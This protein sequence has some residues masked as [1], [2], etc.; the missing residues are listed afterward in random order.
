MTSPN[1]GALYIAF[2]SLWFVYLKLNYLFQ[3]L[4]AEETYQYENLSKA[5][6]A[7]FYRSVPNARKTRDLVPSNNSNIEWLSP[8]D[9]KKA[10]G[11]FEDPSEF[12]TNL[13]KESE[14]QN[15]QTYNNLTLCQ[16]RS[17]VNLMNNLNLPLMP[18]EE[19]D[20]DA[21]S[22]PEELK[23]FQAESSLNLTDGDALELL[24]NVVIKEDLEDG[25]D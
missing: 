5:H 1:Y 6:Y 2:I 9:M 8:S 17:D 3:P 16:E 13:G 23:D 10:L 19:E 11:D 15:I 21:L 20:K 22:L 4:T 12:F 18:L 24:N 7:D 14:Q 25:K